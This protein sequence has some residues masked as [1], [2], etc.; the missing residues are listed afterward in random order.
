MSDSDAEEIKEE[1]EAKNDG[2]RN[3]VLG[4][5]RTPAVKKLQPILKTR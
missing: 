2:K 4:E 5:K 1:L 3:V